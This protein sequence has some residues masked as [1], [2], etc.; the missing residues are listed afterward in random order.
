MNMRALGQVFDRVEA[1]WRYWLD[2]RSQ[3]AR[4]TWERFKLLLSR[5]P[6]PKPAVVHSVFRIA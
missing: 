1:I 4:M 3:K 2:R 5:L 6:L